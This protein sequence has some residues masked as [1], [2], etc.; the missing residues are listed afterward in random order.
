[1]VCDCREVNALAVTQITGYH[2]QAPCRTCGTGNRGVA[3]IF[4]LLARIEQLGIGRWNLYAC[5]VKDLGVVEA[6]SCG[7][8]RRNCHDLSIVC[9][10]LKNTVCKC[11]VPVCL[12]ICQDIGQICCNACVYVNIHVRSRI[13]DKHIRC[14]ACCNECVEL[15][16]ILLKIRR[17]RRYVI[18]SIIL[19]IITVDD[20][21]V[22]LGDQ[23]LCRLQVIPEHPGDLFRS[24]CLYRYCCKKAGCHCCSKRYRDEFFHF[25]S[26]YP[27]FLLNIF[28]TSSDGFIITKQIVF[29]FI[30]IAL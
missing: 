29:I 19:L 10:S 6:K 26:T 9:H 8:I 22:S 3:C 15:S 16:V 14:L 23:I 25:H 30:I 28:F 21:F 2:G 11:G 20:L 24:V 7:K 27:P 17:D 5:R 4:D 18:L 12:L 1:M 13:A